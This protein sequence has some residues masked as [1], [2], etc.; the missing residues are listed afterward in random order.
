MSSTK[1]KLNAGQ[2][3]AVLHRNGPLLVVAGAGT[4]K[5]TVLINRLASILETEKIDSDRILLLT[6]TEKSAQEMEERADRLLPYGYLDLWINTFHGFC[7]RILREHALDIGLPADFRVL[8]ATEQWMLVKK[9]LNLFDLDYYRPLGNPTKFISELLKHFSRL[10]D[11]NISASEYLAYAATAT[12]TEGGEA[13]ED[14][15]NN[16]MEGSRLRELAGAYDVYNRLLLDNSWVDFGD[17]IIYTLKLFRERPNILKHYHDRF[18]YIMV[19][20]F[21]DTNWAQYELVKLLGVPEN[22]IMVVGDDDQAIYRFRGASLANIMQFK[23]DFPA[24]PEIVLTENYRS[25]Q[26]IL[27]I[28]HEFIKHNNPNRLE[29]KLKIE[30]GLVAKGEAAKLGQ[31]PVFHLLDRQEDELAFVADKI[32]EIY[33]RDRVTGDEDWS[34]FAILA[35]SNDAAGLFVKELTRRGIPNQFVSLRGLYFKPII[36]DCLAYLRLLDNYHESTAL[37]RVLG[38]EPFKVTHSDIISLNRFARLK[39]W[40][41]FETLNKAELVPD[42]SADAL[43]AINRLLELITKHSALVQTTLPSRL[44]FKF[45]EE[46]GLLKGLNIDTDQETFSYLNQFYQKIKRFEEGMSEVKLADFMEAMNL[47]L[48]AGESGSLRLDYID[49]ETVKVMTVHAAKGLEFP[50]VFVVNLADKK[51]PTI[52]RSE[53][54]PLPAGLVKE[55]LVDSKD[56]HT[57]EERRLFY[58][59]LTRAKQELY[60]TCAK[61]Y[62][63]AREKKVSRFA[64]EA[65]IIP[66]TSGALVEKNELL[67]DLAAE[68]AALIEEQVSIDQLPKRFSFSQ[69]AAY[70]NCPLQYKYA[71]IL[72]IPAPTD[73]PSLIFGRLMHGIFYDYLKPF[74]A[75]FQGSLFPADEAEQMASFER[76]EQLLASHWVEDGYESAEQRENYRTKAK[77]ALKDFHASLFAEDRKP[78]PY[79]LEKN[80][81][82]KIGGEILK[83]AIDRVDRV[84]GG[85]EVVDYKTGK[86]KEKLEWQDRRQLILYQLFLEE[87]LQMRVLSLKY[88]YVEGGKSLAFV[89]KEK[90]KD[91]LKLEVIAQI[92]AIKERRFLPKP[93]QMCQFCD[94]KNICEFKQR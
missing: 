23:D 73:K 81:S 31:P 40:S 54:I 86:P 11:E 43:P 84:E 87:V 51:F 74:T 48:E 14:D 58:V 50:Y 21:Q 18:K 13:D 45:V 1:A 76:L 25:R 80:F 29:D 59:A 10:K 71:F 7:E 16:I 92:A 63:G 56:A 20:E 52:N 70:D 35:R 39:A 72:K 38:L 37:F 26:D 32:T 47:E 65:G 67:R 91:K 49:A 42:L 82:F 78:Q 22:N 61:D 44:F 9:N 46:S 34:K 79:F 66:I 6:F 85:V 62:G 68:G 28:A 2:Q 94:F 64:E 75:D 90:E 5:T 93:N 27:D 24:A 33:E 12:S 88:Y 36:L 77:Q 69:L 8:S 17:L 19:D 41:L 4:G 83:G 30:K 55:I 53:K 15:E 57:E 3:A 89:P 60:L